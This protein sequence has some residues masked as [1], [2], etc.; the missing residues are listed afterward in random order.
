MV[1]LFVTFASISPYGIAQ[2]LLRLSIF[3]SINTVNDISGHYEIFHLS[4]INTNVQR[5][6]DVRV[7]RLLK[8]F[9]FS[10]RL[11]VQE[12]A[13]P[14]SAKLHYTFN[15]LQIYIEE[16]FS[17]LSGKDLQARHIDKQLTNLTF[18]LTCSAFSFGFLSV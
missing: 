9:I 5:V 18:F 4:L 10:D 15:S 8:S 16:V 12:D 14:F 6:G 13:K 7:P 3:T 1:N 2:R 11:L 17:F